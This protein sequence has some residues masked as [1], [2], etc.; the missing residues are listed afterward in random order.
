MEELEF[1]L[2]LSIAST[3]LWHK[4]FGY[5]NIL[6]SQPRSIFNIDLWTNEAKKNVYG[7]VCY[8]MNFV[9]VIISVL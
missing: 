6:H 3:L 1:E 2:L 9:C 7:S 5:V 4:L 8:K